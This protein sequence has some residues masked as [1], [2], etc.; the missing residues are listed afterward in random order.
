MVLPPHGQQLPSP[1]LSASLDDHGFD[2]QS[3]FAQGQP[4]PTSYANHSTTWTPTPSSAPI[5]TNPSRKRSRDESAFDPGPDGSYFPSQQVATP[6]PIPEEEPIYGEGMVLINPSTGMSVSAES[7][8]GTWYEEKAEEEKHTRSQS[9]A[10]DDINRPEI[11]LS[12]KSQRLDETAPPITAGLDDIAQAVLPASPPKTSASLQEPRV[13]DFTLTLGIGWTQI[14][15]ASPNPSQEDDGAMQAAARGW[16]KYIENHFA[17]E[18]QPPVEVLAKSKGLNAYLVGSPGGFFLFNDDLSEGRFVAPN[19]QTAIEILR[20]QPSVLEGHRALRANKTVDT[21]DVSMGTNTGLG[22]GF[23]NN[24]PPLLEQSL[25]V[26]GLNSTTAT[27]ITKE[28]E[29]MDID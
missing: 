7:Q 1:Q 26:N 17:G 28:N 12:R 4:S 25:A 22:F 23:G 2:E 3:V 29:G 6:A 10:G 5:S 19:W 9:S 15:S 27:T 24:A 18:V 11:P 20:S 13:D 8:T 14:G 21:L 16:A